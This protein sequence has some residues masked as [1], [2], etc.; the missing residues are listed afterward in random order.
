M[1]WAGLT[2]ILL[3]LVILLLR[4]KADSAPCPR[5]SKRGLR[6]VTA[7]PLCG[8]NG[9]V[10]W[11]YHACSLCGAKLTLKHGAWSDTPE[12]EWLRMTPP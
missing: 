10:D 8:G 7:I 12:E 9:K 4:R 6:L 2:A 3:F 1:K 5:C 11:S